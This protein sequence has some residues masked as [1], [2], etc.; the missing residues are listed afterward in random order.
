MYGK[1]GQERGS[2]IVCVRTISLY[3]SCIF[4]RGHTRHDVICGLPCCLLTGCKLRTPPWSSAALFMAMVPRH[5]ICTWEA[6]LR[7]VGIETEPEGNAILHI[8]I[9]LAS[10]HGEFQ[11]LHQTSMCLSCPGPPMEKTD[12]CLRRLSSKYPAVPWACRI[13]VKLA[14]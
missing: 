11:V 14:E 5:Y 8:G 12:D 3:D 9:S 4:C 7:S 10:C 13:L 2:H 6:L 1:R